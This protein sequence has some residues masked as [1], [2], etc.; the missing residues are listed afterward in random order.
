MEAVKYINDFIF[1]VTCSSG[2]EDASTY[3]KVCD[4]GYYKTAPG[5]G[6]CTACPSTPTPKQ[7]TAYRGTQVDWA[8]LSKCFSV[9]A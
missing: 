9:S 1:S 5:A 7:W 3:C 4:Y 6:S 8:C 2:S